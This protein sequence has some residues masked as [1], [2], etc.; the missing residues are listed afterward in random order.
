MRMFYSLFLA[1]LFTF[2]L[3]A[4]E[5]YQ[6]VDLGLLYYSTSEVTSL[7]NLGQVCGTSKWY[8]KNYV[9]F[10]DPMTKLNS[11]QIRT[12]SKPILNNQT[13]I[14]GSQWM[15]AS[16]GFWEFDEESLFCWQNPSSFF[17]L[18]NIVNLYFPEDAK[19]TSAFER[20]R[21]VLWDVNDQ[22]Q[23]VVMNHD[24]IKNLFS[25]DAPWSFKY[26][27]WIYENDN[28]HQIR[29]PN[30]YVGIKINNHSQVLGYTFKGKD[31]FDKYEK[32]MTSIYNIKD[33]TTHVLDFP[34][35]TFGKDIND[36]GQVVGLY[37]NP[38]VNAMQGFLY[39]PLGSVLTFENFSPVAINNHNC[40]IGKFLK[41]EKKDKPAIWENDQ[42][43]DLMELV[44]LTDDHNQVWDSLDTLVDINDAGHIIGQGKYKG[45]VHGFLLRPL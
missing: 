39:E 22:G 12:T 43:Y 18:F 7:N 11:T 42:I 30:F 23:I 17:T 6:L 10:W 33:Q 41:G 34:S 9:F 25:Y 38:L 28:Y 29:D 31:I 24:S 2:N 8:N 5:R 32:I 3:H 26:R 35:N 36:S 20:E 21:S 37:L 44:D 15:I 13:E 40:I 1:M 4:L 45:A 19:R 27:V 14:F 16:D